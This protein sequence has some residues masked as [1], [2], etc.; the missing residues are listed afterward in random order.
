MSTFEYL[1][2]DASGRRKKGLLEGDSSRH[3]RQQLRERGLTLL[4]VEEVVTRRPRLQLARLWQPRMRPQ[5]LGLITRLLATLLRSGLPLDDALKALSEQ[6][7]DRAVKRVL[8][9]VRNRVI[10]GHPLAAGMRL[11]PHIFPEVYSATI[12]AGEHTRHLPLVLERLADYIDQRNQ[13]RQKLHLALLYPAILTVTAILI[14]AGLLTYVV[15]EIVKVFAHVNRELPGITRALISLSDASRNHGILALTALVT[16]L[17][18]V[19]ALL[20]KPVW[21]LRY[22]AWLLRL[23]V[24]GRVIRE[25]HAAHLTRTLGILL[26][27]GVSMIEALNIAAQGLGNLA[28]REAAEDAVAKVREGES[29]HRALQ[30]TKRLP[31]LTIHLIANGEASGQ[32]ETMLNTAAQ[33]HEQDLHA[34]LATLLALL[35]PFIILIMGAMVL[36]I[37]IAILLPIFELNQLI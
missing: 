37:V 23:P 24:L 13:L 2:L 17:L 34:L 3:V 14:V 10:E 20:R 7:E 18:A 22:H 28:I 33:A 12:A 11:F 35:E 30:S 21:R 9:G 16:G 29:L 4:Q 27:S 26:T 19:R 31:S 6:H 1:S 8:F 15:P 25:S 36:I 5:Q 32:L